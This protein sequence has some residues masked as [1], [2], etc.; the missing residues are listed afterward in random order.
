[1]VPFHGQGMNCAFEDCVALADQLDTHDD[2]ASAFAAFEVARRDDAAAIQ[3][4]ALE[5][6]LEMRDRVDDA[7]FLLQRQ[8]EQQLQARLPTRFVPRY[9]MVTFMRTRYSIA[10]ARSQVQRE[11]LVEA[12]RGHD[13]LS[14]IDWSALEAI[15]HAR[16]QPLD[17]AH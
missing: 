17:G 12:T 7:D 10:L 13:D 11:I 16:L 2:L 14:H 4:M 8:L 3:Q 15:V 6:Y 1:M 9:T 5:N